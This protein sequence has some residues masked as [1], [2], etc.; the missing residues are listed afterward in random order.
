MRQNVAEMAGGGKEGPRLSVDVLA[1]HL[2]L[3][4]GEGEALRI[5]SGYPGPLLAAAPQIRMS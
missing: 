3:S 2:K 1:Q 4:P 5:V